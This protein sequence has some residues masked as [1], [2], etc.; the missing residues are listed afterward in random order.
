MALPR[1]LS[2]W[3][4]VTLWFFLWHEGRLR[5]DRGPVERSHQGS[6]RNEWLAAI[7]EAF[8]LTLF[9]AL[10]FASL[11]HGGWLLL[12][13][14]VAIL[15]EVPLRLRQHRSPILPWREVAL[16]VIRILVAGGLLAWRLG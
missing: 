4:V 11:G 1:L 14:F 2:A 16:G 3:L 8:V 9:A 10:W 13:L 12:F 6:R 5:L 15:V 7:L